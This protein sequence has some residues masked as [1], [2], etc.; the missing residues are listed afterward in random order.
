MQGL[1]HTRYYNIG[2]GNTGKYLVQ[3]Q[4]QA[5]SCGMKLPEVHGI[6]KGLDPNI[7]PEKQVVNQ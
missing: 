5:K 4:S 3:T 7:W 1:L 2:E 6:D